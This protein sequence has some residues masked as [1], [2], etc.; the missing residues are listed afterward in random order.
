MKIAQPLTFV[1]FVFG[2]GMV[3]K[4]IVNHILIINNHYKPHHG[5]Q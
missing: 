2:N 1:E 3:C 5:E 4:L